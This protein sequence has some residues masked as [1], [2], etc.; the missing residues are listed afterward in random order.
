MT[1]LDETHDPAP[2]PY[3][4]SPEDAAAGGIDLAIEVLILSAKMRGRC[5]REGFASI[6]FGD[7]VGTVVPALDA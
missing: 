6:G 1:G 5:A 7:C 4:T 2:L 3:P